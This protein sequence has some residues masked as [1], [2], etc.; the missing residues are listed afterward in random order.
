MRPELESIRSHPFF[1]CIDWGKLENRKYDRK[2][3]TKVCWR[4][5]THIPLAMFKACLGNATLQSVDSGKIAIECSHPRLPEF[6][7]AVLEQANNNFA[8]GRMHVDYKCPTEL[9]HDAMHG[10]TCRAPG[11][12]V[13]RRHVCQCDLPVDWNKG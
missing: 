8:L 9:A 7:K 10:A 12:K 6:K 13:P 3:T 4:T 5:L 2:C 11:S 1:A